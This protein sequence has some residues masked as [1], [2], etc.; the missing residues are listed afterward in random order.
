MNNEMM[1]TTV[2][3]FG[4]SATVLTIV[5]V[6]VVVGIFA[7]KSTKHFEKT[8]TAVTQQQLLAIAKS[9]ADV[10]TRQIMEYQVELQLL[11]SDLRIKNAIINNESAQD[12]LKS[13]GYSPEQILYDVRSQDFDGLYR[14]NAEGIVQS[15]IP[16]RQNRMGADFSR[17]PGVKVVIET[18][19]PHISEIFP[20]FSGDN[21][22]S[23]CYPVF[24]DNLFI[25]IV[26]AMVYPKTLFKETTAMKV[27][28]HG[29]VQIFDNDGT[30]VA[31]PKADQIGE[32]IL[33]L[34]K[35]AFPGYDWSAMEAVAARM[36]RGE[37]GV[38]SYYSV[39]WDA[40][41]PEF[42]K[43]L[44]AFVPIRLGNELWS[45]GVV[46]DYD[47]V[48]GPVR[49]HARNVSIAAGLL[50]LV[51]G[52]VGL[53]FCRVQK[54][55]NELAAK[56]DS[57]E[58]LKAMNQQLNL[59]IT[60]RKQ[61]EVALRKSEN[62]FKKLFME[63][64][65]GVALI[66]SLT[67][68]IYEANPMFAKITGR[69]MEELAQL[70]WMDI[71][72]PDDVQEDLDN[73]ARL[74][75]GE[76]DGFQMEKRC[77]H[78][79]GAIVW[80]SMTIAPVLVEDTTHPRHLCIIEDIT[81]RKQIES[82]L[83]EALKFESVATLAGGIAHQFNNALQ[84]I[85]G[86]VELMEDDF[87][88][89]EKITY[90][91]R[92]FKTAARRMAKLTAQLLAYARGGKYQ[93]KTIS[94]NDFVE[95]T[96]SSVMQLIDSDLHVE[97]D[98]HPHILKVKAD[99]IQMEMVLSEIFFN[100]FEAIEGEGNIR[101]ACR[102]E[103]LTE[104]IAR[105]YPGLKPG[106]YVCLTISDDGK[107]MDEETRKRVFDPFFTTNFEGR[108]LGMSA[109]YGFIKNHDGC[110]MVDS[111]FGKGTTVKIYLPAVKTP[112]REDAKPKTE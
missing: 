88:G 73:M 60:D 4:I 3:K 35:K 40:D 24:K 85:T 96:L 69:T 63:A 79:G 9:Q 12:I 82:R 26:R 84:I 49:D 48:S 76:I 56:A 51:L 31:H 80:I 34:R 68:H 46:M 13:G 83:Q 61:A 47:E 38:G 102:N 99:I 37:E 7:R 54:E 22:I 94:L 11:A 66:D 18:H 36:S 77:I 91:V 30:M 42:V 92:V 93:P 57:A 98:F 89:D 109:A 2:R 65:L 58:K 14:L 21:C 67:D 10:I 110:I 50:I 106:T 8:I 101:I 72:H 107:G 29:Y 39:W 20:A 43:K 95:D 17:K 111:E 23:I 78:R 64:P 28:N 75:A 81:E 52:Y 97:T 90:Y 1:K 104:Q 53:W 105:S 45:L 108:G 62:L 74:N 87:S 32:D 59:E 16:F 6:A 33:A 27:G 70:D 112:F 15:R 44:T 41:K 71:T 5:A 55:K 25:G 86:N 100:A 103:V 19:K